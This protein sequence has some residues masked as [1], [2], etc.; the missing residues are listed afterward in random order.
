MGEEEQGLAG[1]PPDKSNRNVL[2]APCRFRPPFRQSPEQI[3]REDPGRAFGQESTDEKDVGSIHGCRPGF[4]GRCRLGGR[5]FGR[6]PD[7]RRDDEDVDVDDKP[8]QWSENSTGVKLDELKEGDKVK[9]MFEPNQDGHNDVMEI[10][11][12]E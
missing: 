1:N 7:H 9:V 11:K 6:S 10:I 2:F 12:E 5:G 8:L 4:H 3:V